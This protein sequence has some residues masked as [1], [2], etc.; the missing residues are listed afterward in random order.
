MSS[1]GGGGVDVVG[2]LDVTLLELP[3]PSGWRKTLKPKKS[4]TRRK[5]EIVFTAPSGEDGQIRRRSARISEKA[6]AVAPPETKP[7]EKRARRSAEQKIHEPEGEEATAEEFLENKQQ[8]ENPN[9]KNTQEPVGKGEVYEV[10]DMMEKVDAS[11]NTRND[12]TQTNANEADVVVSAE[13]QQ[14]YLVPNKDVD[15]SGNTTKETL[16]DNKIESIEIESHNGREMTAENISGQSEPMAQPG[17]AISEMVDIHQDRNEGSD[18]VSTNQNQQQNE[19]KASRP[20]SESVDKLEQAQKNPVKA[21]E[22]SETGFTMGKEMEQKQQS[23][24][25]HGRIN[26]QQHLP[27]TLSC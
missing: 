15:G 20:S 4:G 11:K 14:G 9:L 19:P 24:K 17:L 27:P 25:Q 3:A 21:N 2:E 5:N 7:R 1:S 26:A 13:N 10:V 16:P 6:K 18:V 22:G 23:F 8:V 12:D